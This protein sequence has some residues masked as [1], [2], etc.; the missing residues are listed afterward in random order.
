MMAMLQA[1]SLLTVIVLVAGECP[2][3]FTPYK[4]D[5]CYLAV[6]KSKTWLE[7]EKH[8]NSYTSC[9]GGDIGHLASV[10]SLD[11]NNFVTR[12]YDMISVPAQGPFWIGMNDQQTEGNF[13]W[14][15]GWSV[16]YRNFGQSNPVSNLAENCVSVQGTDGLQKGQWGDEVC[17][18]LYPYICIIPNKKPVQCP[19]QP[20]Q[21]V[22]R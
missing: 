21:G 15:D 8:C 2:A 10:H 17:T 9:T 6:A 19:G 13:Q 7:A 22:P 18:R 4:N 1:L 5:A 20:G 12:L 16:T 14:S 3:D 11:E